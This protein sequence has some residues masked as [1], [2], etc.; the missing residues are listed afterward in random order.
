M[1]ANI[2]GLKVLNVMSY[3]LKRVKEWQAFKE[4]NYCQH[5]L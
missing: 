2:G 1:S 5:Q 3:L 4:A